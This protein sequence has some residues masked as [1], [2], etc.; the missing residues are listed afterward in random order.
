MYPSVDDIHSS[1]DE[2]PSPAYEER[3][4]QTK[5]GAKPDEYRR[6]QMILN[7]WV[8]GGKKGA[9]ELRKQ[10]QALKPRSAKLAFLMMHVVPHEMKPKKPFRP[11]KFTQ[12]DAIEKEV[13]TITMVK[14]LC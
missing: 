8:Q 7:T 14:K 11:S 1:P 2:A 5:N 4:G 9:A 13:R 6:R 3:E 10:C 12:A